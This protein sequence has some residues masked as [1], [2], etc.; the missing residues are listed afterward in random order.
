MCTIKVT[1]KHKNKNVIKD[2]ENYSFTLQASLRKMNYVHGK[3]IFYI[4]VSLILAICLE[5]SMTLRVLVRILQQLR[6]EVTFYN[7]K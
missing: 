1:Y 7:F 3:L 4:Q 2:L 6:V 5:K